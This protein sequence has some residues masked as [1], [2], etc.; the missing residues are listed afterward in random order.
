[1]GSGEVEHRIRGVSCNHPE[2]GINEIG[3]EQPAP[4]ANLDN[5]SITLSHGLEEPEDPR[6]ARVS[7]ESKAPMVDERE[8]VSVIGCVSLRV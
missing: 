8:V 4:T 1:M 2:S 6:C 5:Q 7:V 3:G